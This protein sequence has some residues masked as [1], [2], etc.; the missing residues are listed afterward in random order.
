VAAPAWYLALAP[1]ALLA[2]LTFGAGTWIRRH[3]AEQARFGSETTV[4]SRSY[5]AVA[6]LMALGW[7][8][9]YVPVRERFWVLGLIG[10]L[11]FL[12]MAVKPGTPTLVASAAFGL[13]GMFV[14]VTQ[15][16]GPLS[17]Y[18]PNLLTILFLRAQQQVARR[19]PERFKLAESI[20]TAMILIGGLALW[21]FISRWV[22]AA[23]GRGHFYLTA[24]W[25]GLALAIFSAGFA[26]R[27]RIDRWLGLGILMCALGRVVLFDIWKLETIYRILSFMAL[28]V[29]LLVLG[30]IYNRYQ[31]KI[32]AWL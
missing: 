23:S 32:K 31:E 29:V 24:S 11:L 8:F 14:F 1:I 15:M 13:T 9:E 30:Y 12:A 25:A 17:G 2:L 6:L 28:G 19:L 27:E 21:L 7:V 26:L 20:H 10:G 16:G 5:A 4:L 22:T 18:W 3:P